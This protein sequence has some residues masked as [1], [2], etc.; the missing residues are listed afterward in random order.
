MKPFF[1]PACVSK[2]VCIHKHPMSTFL[3]LC[4][5]FCTWMRNNFA[6]LGNLASQAWSVCLGQF[7]YFAGTCPC[8]S[9]TLCVGSTPQCTPTVGVCYEIDSVKLG[10]IATAGGI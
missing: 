5:P 1:M 9:C 7:V 6:I 2:H 4:N 8:T 10:N 3:L